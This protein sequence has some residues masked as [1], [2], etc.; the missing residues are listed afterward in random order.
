MAEQRA[1]PVICGPTGSGKTAATLELAEEFPLEII[2]ADSRQIIR[3][4][5]IGTAKPTREEQHRVPFHL[6]DCVALGERYSAFRFIDDATVAI[7]EILLRGH[8]PVVVG[9]TGLYLRGLTEGIVEIE[10]A[11]LSVRAQLDDEM[12][13]LGPERMYDRLM[14]I[15]PLEAARIHPNNRVRVIRALEIFALTGRT[16]SELAAT[17]RYRKSVHTFMYYCLLPSREE[18]YR[19]INERVDRMV[20]EGLLEEIRRIIDDGGEDALRTANI[21]GYKE[22]L[23][24]LAG[25]FGF[26]EAVALIKQNHRRYAKRQITWFRHQADC[27]FFADSASLVQAVRADLTSLR[28]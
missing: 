15:D 4:L 2:S 7:E 21:L 28:R 25:R 18:L 12:A 6:I 26:E 10:E 11:D 9:G 13:R 14:H 24:Y 16:K 19:R 3:G 22:V 8:L 23:D 27:A 20:D 17:G 5:D 1:I